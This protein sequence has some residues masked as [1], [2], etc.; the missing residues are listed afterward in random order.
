M[1]TWRNKRNLAA[2]SWETQEHPRN[3]QSQNTSVPGLTEEYVTQVSEEVEGRVPEK[4]SRELSRTESRILGALSKIDEFLWNPQV[5]TL[6]GT[7][8]GTSRNNGMENREPAGD[9]S[10]N[11]PHPEV[12]FSSCRSSNSVDSDQ[13]ETSHTTKQRQKPRH[14]CNHCDSWIFTVYWC[15]ILLFV[16][17]TYIVASLLL[18]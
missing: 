2:V 9:R 4:L 18:T 17:L 10:Q 14:L 5:R 7:V 1:A 16:L 6:S 12:E 11:D 3:S 8:P 13:E 15:W